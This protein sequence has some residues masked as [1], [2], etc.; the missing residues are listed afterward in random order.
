MLRSLW[1]STARNIDAKK[2]FHLAKNTKVLAAVIHSFV[3]W[4]SGCSV[5]PV[6]RLQ[7]DFEH[8]IARTFCTAS[9]G[10][11]L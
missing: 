3:N 8:W 1:R 10:R 9:V 2:N 4:H 5:Q 7:G 11:S 6:Q